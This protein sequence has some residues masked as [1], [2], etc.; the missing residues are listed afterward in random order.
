LTTDAGLKVCAAIQWTGRLR[1][2]QSN[3]APGS[4]LITG[5]MATREK[6]PSS[7][8]EYVACRLGD[9]T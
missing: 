2:G 1:I 8:L 6:G 7:Q 3:T 5:S 4:G 9:P